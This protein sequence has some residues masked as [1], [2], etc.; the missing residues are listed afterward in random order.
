VAV[1]Y[2]MGKSLTGGG[3]RRYLWAS[4]MERFDMWGAAKRERLEIKNWE[5]WS[6]EMRRK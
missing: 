5:H 3:S 2:L 6:W 4:F 1:E